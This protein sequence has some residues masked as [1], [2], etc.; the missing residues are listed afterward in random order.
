VYPVG[1]QC[2]DLSYTIEGYPVR[3]Y[4]LNLAQSTNS[5]EADLLRLLDANS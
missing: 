1:E 4:T 2:I 5:I 3:I